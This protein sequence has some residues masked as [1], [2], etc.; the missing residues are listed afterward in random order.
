MADRYMNAAQVQ[1]FQKAHE[2][3][4]RALHEL[5]QARLPLIELLGTEEGERAFNALADAHDAL[6]GLP[7]ALVP[8]PEWQGGDVTRYRWPHGVRRV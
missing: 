6:T 5:Y 4:A 2:H 3:A 1:A 8:Q 7:Y